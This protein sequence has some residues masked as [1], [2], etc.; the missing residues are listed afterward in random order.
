MRAISAVELFCGAGG[1][2][3]GINMAGKD[4]K[5]HAGYDIDSSCKYPY[6]HNNNAK[7]IAKSVDNLSA[8]ELLAHYKSGDIR[9]LAGCA[10]CQPF[11]TYSQGRDA[12]EDKKWPLLYQF[13]RL[14][15]E[16]SPELVTMEN[17]PDVIKHQVYVDFVEE[18]EGLGYHVWADSVFCPDYGM[19]Q[20]R[21]RHVLLASKLGPISLIPPTHKPDN[22][23]TVREV[24]G[25]LPSLAAGEQHQNDP[26]HKASGLSKLNLERIKASKPGGTWRDWPI[27]LIAACHKKESGK[28]YSGVYARMQWDQPSPT[29]TTQCFGFGNGRFGHPEQN[30]AIS[31]REAA[32]FQTFPMNYQFVEQGKSVDISTLGRMIGNAVPVDLGKV[33]G[34]TLIQHVKQ[35]ST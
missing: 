21:R 34:K 24:I 9:L 7:F 20:R 13:A 31:L 4:I 30:R 27:R 28:S 1:L 29:M 18:L 17:V 16:V 5:V 22:Y 19:P 25:N 14:I 15:R 33:I 8:E 3:C 12:R 23:K 10:P 26:I 6:E 35:L 32:L 11:S 2:T